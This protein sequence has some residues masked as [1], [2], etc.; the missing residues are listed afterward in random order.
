[1]ANHYGMKERHSR[2]LWR[3]SEWDLDEDRVKSPAKADEVHE[4]IM[5]ARPLGSA[6]RYWPGTTRRIPDLPYVSN[7]RHVQR[8]VFSMYSKTAM[9]PESEDTTA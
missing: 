2:H 4:A 9:R 3:L 8:F 1:M 5:T 7:A 6:A